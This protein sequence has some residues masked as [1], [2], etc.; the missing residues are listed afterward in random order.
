MTD[1]TP[2]GSAVIYCDYG[3]R[4]GRIRLAAVGGDAPPREIAGEGEGYEMAA[5]ASPDGRW[6]AYITTKIRREEVCM[7]RLDGSGASWQLSTGRGG[8]PRWGR[9]GRELFLVTG[10]TLMRVSIT[11]RGDDLSIGQPEALFEV[12]PTP[13]EE[14]FRD[15]DYDPIG[16][17]FL[18]TRP[19][20]GVAD[21]REIALSLGWA[22]RLKTRIGEKQEQLK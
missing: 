18:F 15:H 10:E 19:P 8:G 22:K 9:D 11:A 14:A 4:S 17:R 20:R 1:V 21:R 12:P 7:R 2:D 13:N 5:R 16:D 3:Q 6:L